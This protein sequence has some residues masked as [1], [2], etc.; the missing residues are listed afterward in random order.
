MWTISVYSTLLLFLTWFD[1]VFSES[2]YKENLLKT[3][4]HDKARDAILEIFSDFLYGLENYGL[5]IDVADPYIADLLHR[6]KTHRE[7]ID[8]LETQLKTAEKKRI[9]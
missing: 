9:N 7:R 6:N 8:K 4:D 1:L 3:L 5:E 2:K